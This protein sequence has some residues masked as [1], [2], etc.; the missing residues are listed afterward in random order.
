MHDTLAFIGAGEL[1]IFLLALAIAGSFGLF[2]HRV[3]RN[4]EKPTEDDL[5]EPHPHAHVHH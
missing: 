5:A 2:I 3:L 1:A 4:R